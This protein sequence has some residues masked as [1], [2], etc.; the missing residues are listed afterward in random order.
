M[1]AGAPERELGLKKKGD[2]DSRRDKQLY[3]K[4]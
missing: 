3:I 2:D 4:M 1:N